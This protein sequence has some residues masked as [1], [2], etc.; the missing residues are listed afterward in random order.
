[1]NLSTHTPLHL[2]K[3]SD[4]WWYYCVSECEN[5]I[6]QTL[7][8]RYK[9]CSLTL[10]SVTAPD[11][12]FDQQKIK[13]KLFDLPMNIWEENVCVGFV[14]LIQSIT[15]INSSVNF[16]LINNP[17]VC[18][19]TIIKIFSNGAVVQRW[20]KL[21]MN[22]MKCKPTEILKKCLTL[23]QIRLKSTWQKYKLGW[24]LS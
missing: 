1:M 9:L 14:D 21:I 2:R 8:P 7:R 11:K 18:F 3:Q 6:L 22:I 17:H 4:S 23:P 12:I 15:P 16:D 13:K 24:R 10:T 19:L 5:K 20:A